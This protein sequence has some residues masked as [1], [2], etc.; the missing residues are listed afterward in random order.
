MRQLLGLIAV[1]LTEGLARADVGP[2]IP[3]ADYARLIYVIEA[4]ESFPDLVFVIARQDRF[5]STQEVEFVDLAPGHPITIATGYSVS[6]ELLI[7]PAAV[8]SR[9]QSGRDLVQALRVTTF[10]GVVRKQLP[11]RALAPSWAGR[12]ITITYRLTRPADGD[13]PELI[14]TSPDPMMSWYAAALL[15]SSGAALVG[16]WIIR[17]IRRRRREL[18]ASSKT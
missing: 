12:E 4:N 17:R 7:I 1:L 2:P 10:P 8:A 15:S 13:P 16:F 3:A 9:Y 11:F 6:T 14:R 5:G 18:L